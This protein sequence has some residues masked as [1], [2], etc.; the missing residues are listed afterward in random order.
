MVIQKTIAEFDSRFFRA[1]Y[2]APDGESLYVRYGVRTGVARSRMR[3]TAALL[4]KGVLVI[5]ILLMVIAWI[6]G[7]GLERA[8]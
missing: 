5:S 7:T 2:L 1:E 4:G 6:V 3:R 8:A